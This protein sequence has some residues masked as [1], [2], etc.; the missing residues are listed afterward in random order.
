MAA[1]KITATA[2][3]ILLAAGGFVSANATPIQGGNPNAGLSDADCQLTD[4]T[5][6]GSDALA[7]AGV[8]TGGQGG[9]TNIENLAGGWDQVDESLGESPAISGWIEVGKLDIGDPKLDIGD[10][11]STQSI[12]L[13]GGGLLEYG[14]KGS[15]MVDVSP[16]EQ[17]VLS[18]KQ[19]TGHAFYYFEVDGE[20]TYQLSWWPNDM[21]ALSNL[22]VFVQPVPAPGALALLGGGLLLIGL[23]RRRRSRG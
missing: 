4:V 16:F 22:T 3:A 12:N 11:E 17:F 1:S 14:G 5:I 13:L 6:S 8:F 19:A 23:A 2:A 20:G 15:F 7:C 9:N 21:T 10:P 18:F